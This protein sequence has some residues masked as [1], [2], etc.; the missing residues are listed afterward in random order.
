MI[1]ASQGA[2]DFKIEAEICMGDRQA[3]CEQPERLVKGT[4]NKFRI[5]A[6]QVQRPERIVTRKQFVP[7]IATER[8]G[9]VPTGKTAEKPSRQERSIALGFIEQIKNARQGIH[10]PIEIQQVNMV[11]GF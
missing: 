8:D 10:R 11:L 2:L 7:S 6:G 1:Q 9:D 5:K 4:W 3:R